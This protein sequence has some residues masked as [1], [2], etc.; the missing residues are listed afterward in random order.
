MFGTAVIGMGY[1]LLQ[2]ISF[3]IVRILMK[4]DSDVYRLIE[5]YGDK[6]YIYNHPIITLFCLNH[7]LIILPLINFI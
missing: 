4:K 6:V 1:N 5:F 7:P 3:A 2:M